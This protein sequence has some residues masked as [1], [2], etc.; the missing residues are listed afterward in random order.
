M[1]VF[2]I[3][4]ISSHECDFEGNKSIER[5]YIKIEAQQNTLN[6][7]L[8]EIKTEKIGNSMALRFQKL[9]YFLFMYSFIYFFF[10]KGV[11]GGLTRFWE[12]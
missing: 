1:S 9:C 7:N 2:G 8:F 12:F 3:F 5:V 11:I 4:Q 10:L 6:I